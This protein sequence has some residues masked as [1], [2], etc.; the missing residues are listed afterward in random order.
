M[1]FFSWKP[2]KQRRKV[3][4]VADATNMYQ[5]LVAAMAHDA[6]VMRNVR[7]RK[8]KKNRDVNAKISAANTMMMIATVMDSPARNVDARKERV[9]QQNFQ[10]IQRDLH[11]NKRIVLYRKQQFRPVNRIVI[12]VNFESVHD[13]APDQAVVVDHHLVRVAHAVVP[14]HDQDVRV[15]DLAQ[16]V[17]HVVDLAAVQEAD[18][19]EDQ[20]VNPEAVPNHGVVRNPGAVLGQAVAQE[21]LQAA[22]VQVVVTQVVAVRVAVLHAAD[23]KVIHDRAVEAAAHRKIDLV[24]VRKV[25]HAAV[26]DQNLIEL[27]STKINLFIS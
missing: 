1:L 23:L 25:I 14:D 18:R 20:E 17:V 3:L 21:A 7:K 24:L 8:P 11:R 4:D 26:A 13:R 6:R 10:K 27:H 22:V 5:I 19:K 9:K 2:P 16:A 15:A 12:A